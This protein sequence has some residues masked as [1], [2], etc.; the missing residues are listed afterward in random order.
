MPRKAYKSVVI[1]EILYKK[2]IAHVEQSEGRY[3]TISEVVREAVWN[4]L[5]AS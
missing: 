1:P 5:K 2:I 4:F 3:I